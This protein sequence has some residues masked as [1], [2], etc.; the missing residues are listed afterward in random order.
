M[1]VDVL[2]D[3]MLRKQYDETFDTGRIVEKIDDQV[4][5]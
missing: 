4:C 3:I 2:K 1:I 5:S